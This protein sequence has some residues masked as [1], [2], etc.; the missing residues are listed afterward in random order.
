MLLRNLRKGELLDVVR[1][2]VEV[3]AK[4]RTA[5]IS[6]GLTKAGKRAGVQESVSLG[7]DTAF[8][9]VQHWSPCVR[10]S[11]TLSF[12]ASMAQIV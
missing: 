10:S 2:R 11:E 4:L 3:S 12:A 1:S 8:R 7:H 9:F 6:L 5:V